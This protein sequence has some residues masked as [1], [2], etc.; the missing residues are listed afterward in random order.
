[1]QI[2][3]CYPCLYDTSLATWVCFF[4]KYALFLFLCFCSSL[5]LSASN[6]CENNTCVGIIDVG[7]TGS[8]LH[9]YHFQF[10]KT[11]TP[12]DITEIGSKNI[13]P[14]FASIKNDQESVNAYLNSLFTDIH[15]QDIPVYFYATAGMRL[16]PQSKQKSYY[17]AVHNWFAGHPQWKLAAAKT[18]SG[19]EEALF[20]WLAVNY[21]LGTL[22]NDNPVGMLDIGGAS[23]QI[24]FEVKNPNPSIAKF[25][26]FT[27]Y[28]KNYTVFTQSFLGLGQNEMTHQLLD[29]SVC[30]AN[31]YPLPDGQSGNG[32]AFECEADIARLINSVHKTNMIVQPILAVNPVNTWYAIGG[33]SYLAESKPFQFS[34]H[35]LS[36]NEFLNQAN[37]LACQSSWDD[38][39]RQYPNNDYIDTYCLLPSFY[40]ALMVDGYGLSANEKI[41]VV[42]SKENL[43][44]TL[45]VV[46]HP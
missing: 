37:N 18:I 3:I 35:M 5:G 25:N 45:G 7:S 13:K 33:I 34:E 14:G 46:L 10:D 42:P 15:Y 44:W 39:T 29:S 38:L 9:I 17:Q 26:S 36:N 11:H 20:G 43:D 31:Q 27:L 1:M 2:D 32:N 12:I 21:H 16:L 41:H 24:A 23:V 30:F 19:N 22:Q 8:R 6:D 40:Y 28:D 4:M